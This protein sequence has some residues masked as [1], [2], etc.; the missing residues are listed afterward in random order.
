MLSDQDLRDQLAHV[1]RKTDFQFIGSKYEGKVRDCY[2]RGSERVLITTDRLSCFDV[3]VTC[4]PF[5]GQVLNELAMYWFKLTSDLVPNHVVDVPDPNVMVVKNCEILPVEVVLRGYLAGSAWRDYQAGK[6]VSGVRLP[7]G[8][9]A[10]DKLPEVIITPSTKAPKG[11]HDLPISEAELLAAGLVKQSLWQQVR[12]VALA[13]FARGQEQAE[14]QGL[15]LVDTKYE[16]GQL[17]GKLVLAD[18]IHTLDSSRYWVKA[19]YGE[20]LQDGQA[21]EMLDKEPMRQWL[22]DRGYKGDG[23]VLEF[24]A[25][26]LVGIARHYI[27][28]FERISGRPL[29]A[30]VG[31]VSDRIETKLMAY[32]DGRK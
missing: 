18:E 24:S 8:L 14:Q 20:R 16:F 3:V 19:S 26:H 4:V 32:F 23:P 25:E 12:E 5:K 31:A 21:P 15:I 2:D 22:L 29:E 17:D 13:L 11:S 10:Y 9:K 6:T 27:D 28:S 1:L 7:D 30:K